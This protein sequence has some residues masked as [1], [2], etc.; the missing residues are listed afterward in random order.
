[1]LDA[2]R[3]AAPTS[4]IALAT[5]PTGG[6]ESGFAANY[7]S[8]RT[9]F[10]FRSSILLYNR[11]LSE[12]IAA[13]K[14]PRLVVVPVHHAVDSEKG[15]PDDNALHLT[16]EGGQMIGDALFAWL[17]WSASITRRSRVKR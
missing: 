12:K 6:R 16:D 7:G 17:A 1:M 5:A 2:L 15:Y 3:A 11:M 10:T 4:L 13:R 8:F 14:D 9:A